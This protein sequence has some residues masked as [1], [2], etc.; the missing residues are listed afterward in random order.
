M[1]RTRSAFGLEEAKVAPP[2][3][4]TLPS[5]RSVWVVPIPILRRGVGEF[6]EGSPKLL[7][8]RLI[9]VSDARSDDRRAQR[10]RWLRPLRALQPEQSTPGRAGS[11]SPPRTS[12]SGWSAASSPGRTGCGG[13]CQPGQVQPWRATQASTVL[14]ASL[15]QAD[16]LRTGWSGVRRKRLAKPG[17]PQRSQRRSFVVGQPQRPAWVSQ[18]RHAQTRERTILRRSGLDEPQQASSGRPLESDW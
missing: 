9:A 10:C 2:T 3:M 11:G 12:G 4:S 6:D 15:R 13:R 16:V 8:G 1:W 17:R 7:D 5:G 18:P 14:F